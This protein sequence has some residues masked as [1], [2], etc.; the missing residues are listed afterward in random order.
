MHN[1]IV[2]RCIFAVFYSDR[3][4]PGARSLGAKKARS[5]GGR[6]PKRQGAKEARSLG[7]REP[8]QENGVG[9]RQGILQSDLANGGAFP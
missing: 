9:A 4:S 8:K 1:L 7:G 6:E 2:F 5:L 3:S